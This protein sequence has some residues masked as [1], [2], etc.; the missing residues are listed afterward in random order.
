MDGRD[1]A[2][3]LAVES[4][5]DTHCYTASL[6]QGAAYTARHTTANFNRPSFCADIKKVHGKDIKFRQIILDYFWTPSGTWQS[7]HW[8]ASFFHT[9]LPDF[10]REEL[11]DF[12]PGKYEENDTDSFSTSG[13]GGGVVY[14]PFCLHCVQQIISAYDILKKYYTIEF[15]DKKQLHQ[16][17]L[18]AGT[19][20]IDSK[21]M[22]NWLGKS[23][24]QED[25]YCTITYNEVFGSTIDPN[26]T[27]EELLHLLRMIENFYEIRMIK[28]KAL[29]MYNPS[30]PEYHHRNK[31]SSKVDDDL[32]TNDKQ[33]TKEVQQRRRSGMKKIPKIGVTKGGFIGLKAVGVRNGFDQKRK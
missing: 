10:V 21:A 15:M 23:I 13:K 22:Q 6:E 17:A 33:K 2:R 8:K 14:L 7:S 3:I 30:H 27:K 19:S 32:L 11:I 31:R 28:L 12:K 24:N 1:L 4:S 26:V 29:Q 18:W 25:S 5:N 20:T 16:H 9:T